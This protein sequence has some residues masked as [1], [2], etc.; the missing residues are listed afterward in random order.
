MFTVNESI[1]HIKVRYFLYRCRQYIFIHLLAI[2][3]T[4]VIIIIIICSL[5]LYLD[6]LQLPPVRGAIGGNMVVKSSV[7]D[8]L[9][10][11]LLASKTTTTNNNNSSNESPLVL[12]SLPSIQAQLRKE[13]FCF[14]SPVWSEA[15]FSETDG[16]IMLQEIVRQ[17]DPQ[18]IQ[19]L[20]SIRIG[21]NNQQYLRMLDQCLI[22]NKPL[23]VDGIIPTKLYCMNKDVDFENLQQLNQLPEEVVSIE[24][25]D[26][27]KYKPFSNYTEKLI[28]HTWCRKFFNVRANRS[29]IFD[30]LRPHLL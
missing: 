10:M 29:K 15:G 17:N 3:K 7:S 13:R 9:T 8:S 12:E 2:I 20:N 11:S 4:T 18:F 1:D 5:L 6:F 16:S 21:E 23:P 30:Q 27:W 22:K 25:T 19:V 14:E 26:L 24:A 28:L